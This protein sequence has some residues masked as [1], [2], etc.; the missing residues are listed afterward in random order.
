MDDLVSVG[1]D[2]EDRLARIVAVEGAGS[3][4]RLR[5]HMT[6]ELDGACFGQCSQSP[7]VSTRYLRRLPEPRAPVDV[8]VTTFEGLESAWR[9]YDR[10]WDADGTVAVCLPAR[11]AGQLLRARGWVL[12]RGA[13]EAG[14]GWRAP[15]GERFSEVSDAVQFALLAEYAEAA[16]FGE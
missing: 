4:D 8:P 5:L 10:A 12:L 7:A 15:T 16:A 14:A 3:A 2:S 1:D 13:D 11:A 6:F 9:I